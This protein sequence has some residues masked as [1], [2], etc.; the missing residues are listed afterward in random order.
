MLGNDMDF[1]LLKAAT[2]IFIRP[3]I[4]LLL[5]RFPLNATSLTH[6]AFPARPQVISIIDS[7]LLPRENVSTRGSNH[8][9]TSLV[10]ELAELG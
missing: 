5:L 6:V 4:I 1:F 7:D 8:G 2:L 10:G 3:H 9:A